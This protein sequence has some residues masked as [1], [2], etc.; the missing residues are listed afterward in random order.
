MTSRRDRILES[1]LMFGE[2]SQDGL[3]F[4]VSELLSCAQVNVGTPIAGW[5]TV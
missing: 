1:W 2:S 3:T 5:F 4:Q